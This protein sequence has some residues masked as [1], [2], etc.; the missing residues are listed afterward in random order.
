MKYARALIVS[1]AIVNSSASWADEQNDE[2]VTVSVAVET[3]VVMAVTVPRRVVAY[4][5]VE[6]D[7]TA[8]AV[9]ALPRA[10]VIAAVRVRPGERVSAGQPLMDVETAA[11]PRLQYQQA[12]AA[13]RYAEAQLA[14]VERQFEQQLATRE[15]LAQARRDLAD[16]EAAQRSLRATGADA[17]TVTVRAP[18]PGIVAQLAVAPGDR[19]AA[20]APLLYLALESA[21]VVRVGVTPETASLLARAAPVQL[22]P[23]S[24]NAAPIDAAVL[25][26]QGMLNPATRLV[27]V[28]V[29]VPP[30][31]AGALVLGATLRARIDGAPVSGWLVPR[32]AVLR[33][34]SGDYVYSAVADHA[35]RVDVT[36]VADRNG[37]ML[38][39]GDLSAGERVVI[40]GNYQLGDGAALTEVAADG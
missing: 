17:A 25:A 40:S 26:V 9:V 4:G 19:P 34:E 36:I 18:H 33:D 35:R 14:G 31:A 10:A 22:E 5:T 21:L 8:T 24:P 37:Q 1:L 6:A 29:A 12:V 20:D 13:L 32:S 39:S 7:P 15:Q 27:D 3:A 11:A 28:I 30:E 16:A 2:A 23:L 38:I